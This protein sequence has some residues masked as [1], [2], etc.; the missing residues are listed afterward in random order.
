[1]GFARNRQID[2]RSIRLITSAQIIRPILSRLSLILAIPILLGSLLPACGGGGGGGGGAPVTNLKS[3]TIDPV[4]SSI[5]VGTKLQLHATGTFKNKTTKDITASVTWQSADTSVTIVSNL[6]AIK[7]LAGG[8]GA[9]AT[10]VS[11]TLDG[12]SGVSN[13]TVTKTSLTSIT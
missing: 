10:S 8:I 12:I 5:A 2:W 1:M 13:F 9:G 4:N 7:G 3:I 11:A 6:A